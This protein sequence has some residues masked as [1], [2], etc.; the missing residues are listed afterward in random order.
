MF[1]YQ[2]LTDKYAIAEQCAKCREIL[3]WFISETPDLALGLGK[4]PHRVSLMTAEMS[5]GRVM[6]NVG[7]KTTQPLQMDLQKDT[8][9]IA[10]RRLNSSELTVN[11]HKEKRP[12]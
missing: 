11:L 2:P 6:T 1:N 7:M 9:K 10:P 12:R 3:T 4:P 8:S 5:A